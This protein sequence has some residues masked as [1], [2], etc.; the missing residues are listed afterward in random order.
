[1][2]SDA[3][4]TLEA[5]SNVDGISGPSPLRL[6]LGVAVGVKLPRLPVLPK[7]SWDPVSPRVFVPRP[8]RCVGLLV[9]RRRP[10]VSVLCIADRV[11]PWLGGLPLVA[12]NGGSLFMPSRASFSRDST[13]DRFTRQSL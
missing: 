2:M 8:P 7:I 1:M 13:A 11:L 4:S 9:D 5:M 6:M 3:D 10:M 12:E